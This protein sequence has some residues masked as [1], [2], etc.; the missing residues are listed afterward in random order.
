MK[1]KR[2]SA[3][4]YRLQTHVVA[5]V[6]CAA[7]ASFQYSASSIRSATVRTEL[8]ARV[9]QQQSLAGDS[10]ALNERLRVLTAEVQ[11]HTKSLHSLRQSIPATSNEHAFIEKLASQAEDCGLEIHE[12]QPGDLKQ[13]NQFGLI[14]VRVSALGSWSALCHFLKRLRETE[15][16]C[17]VEECRISVADRSKDQLR[18]KVTIGIF[19]AKTTSL[20]SDPERSFQ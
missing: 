4:R 1:S 9:A 12:L 19:S 6:L 17:G 20:A 3:S 8:E 14:P 2:L 18:I 16:L 7:T 10:E 5:A 15:R 11:E 13:M